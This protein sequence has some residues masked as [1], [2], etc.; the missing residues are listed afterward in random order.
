MAL[1]GPPCGCGGRGCIE[2]LC[3]AAVA[4]GDVAEAARVLGTGAANLVG[5]LDIDR[6]VLGGRTVGADPDAYVRGVRA[7]IEERARRDGTG[8]AVPL[9]TTAGAGRPV[10]EGPRNWSS[11]RCSA[12]SAAAVAHSAVGAA[13][14]W[15]G[16][17]VEGGRPGDPSAWRRPAVARA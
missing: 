2:A 6:V 8:A 1:D 3:L 7:V 10:A 16:R 5:L 15:A 4:E 14:V 11:P 9:V 13:G 17:A 12:V